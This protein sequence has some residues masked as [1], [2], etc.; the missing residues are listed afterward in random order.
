LL[1]NVPK[2]KFSTSYGD[3]FVSVINWIQ[4]NADKSKLVTANEQYYLLRD[5]YKTSWPIA[6][7]EKFLKQAT[8]LWN[9]WQ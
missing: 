8:K 1:Y 6:D 9:E 5:G 7:A 4:Q 3:T 2:E